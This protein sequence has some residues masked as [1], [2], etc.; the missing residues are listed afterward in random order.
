MRNARNRIRRIDRLRKVDQMSLDQLK[1]ELAIHDHLIDRCQRELDTIAEQVEAIQ[2]T[3]AGNSVSQFQLRID[4]IDQWS[5]A[6][7][8]NQLLLQKLKTERE[9]KLKEIVE[10]RSKVRGWEKLLANTTAQIDFDLQKTE[11]LNADDRYL[12]QQ[13]NGTER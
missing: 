3:D 9:T 11:A 5:K 8:A 7:Q 1:N 6:M 2:R 4:N 13:Q 12:S 10:Q